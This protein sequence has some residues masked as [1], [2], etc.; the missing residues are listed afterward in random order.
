V[1]E[2]PQVLPRLGIVAE[3]WFRNLWWGRTISHMGD[4]A[5]RI[6]FATYIISATHSPVVLGA[7][8][9]ALL[10][11]SLVFYLVGG[12]ASDRAAARRTIMI[13]ADLGRCVVTA[14]IAVLLP[15]TG[16]VW[17]LVALA[18][19]VGIGDGFFQP[20]SFAFLK[21][22]VPRDRLANAN[23]AM[24]VSQ[25]IGLIAGPMLGG[26]LVGLAGSTMAFAF[27]AVTFAVSAVF[28]ALI[29]YRP[30]GREATPDTGGPRGVRRV[31]TEVGEGFGYVRGHRWLQ[32]AL[33]VG[34]AANAVFAGALAVTVPLIMA[35]E[36]AA[37]A[38]TLG[39]FYAVQAVGA[40][41][42]ALLVGR[43]R[44]DRL[45]PLLFGALALMAAS[46]AGVGLIGRSPVAYAMA[47]GYG[48]GLHFFNT[49][50]PTVL[51][52]RVPDRLLGRVSSVMT[53]CFTGL[54]P[55]GQLV[56]G[57]LAAASTARV[58]TTAA[59]AV[60]TV[61]CLVTILAPSIRALRRSPA[62]DPV[63]AATA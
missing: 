59:S 31:L 63:P 29:R 11:P 52:E 20:A 12:V 42:G 46:L 28:I 17:L 51:H 7:S 4:Y 13:G 37:D 8:T 58:A 30:A 32:I 38:R 48:I 49:L 53:L 2:R 36:G 39:Q 27:D 60:V 1:R 40:F 56:I 25:Q 6:A 16:E 62:P 34:P 43:V 57:P 3:P 54:M 55:V 10:L 35:P 18:V 26:L 47:F 9:A 41:T 33:L 23:S 44:L 45:G 61:V 5:F 50:F 21:E 14:A 22:I 24:S 15:L 19:L